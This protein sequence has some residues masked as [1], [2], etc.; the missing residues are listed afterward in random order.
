MNA[1][2]AHRSALAEKWE[3]ELSESKKALWAQIAQRLPAPSDFGL[4]L[5]FLGKIAKGAT[6][7]ELQHFIPRNGDRRQLDRRM[8]A[9]GDEAA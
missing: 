7:E 9:A 6:L 2:T 4:E 5:Y 1:G 8:A 3:A